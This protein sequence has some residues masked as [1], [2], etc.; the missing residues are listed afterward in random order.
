MRYAPTECHLVGDSKDTLSAL[1]PLLERKTDRSWREQLEGEIEHWW[2]L[3]DARAHLDAQPINPQLVFAE[4]SPRLPDNCI[5]TS[6]SGS[7]TN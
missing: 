3:M 7:A 4:L 6:D 1:I 2:K 5:L